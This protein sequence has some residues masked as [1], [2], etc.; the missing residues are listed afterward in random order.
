MHGENLKLLSY[1]LRLHFPSALTPQVFR[2]T[3]ER[4]SSIRVSDTH[5]T[6]LESIAL[7]KVIQ[8]YHVHQGDILRVLH[9]TVSI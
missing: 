3:C 8:K 5:L 9:C 6:N 1:L 7:T 4:F 2:Q